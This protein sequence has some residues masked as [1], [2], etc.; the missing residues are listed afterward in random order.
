MNCSGILSSTIDGGNSWTTITPRVR[1]GV[2]TTDPVTPMP[3]S[4]PIKTHQLKLADP[5]P[6]RQPPS[7]LKPLC[8]R[9]ILT[10]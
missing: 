5:K 9:D 7:T 2:L 3:T 1:N 10:L 6:E 4:K 8:G